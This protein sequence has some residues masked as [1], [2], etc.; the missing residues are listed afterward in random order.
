MH[1]RLI[2]IVFGVF[3]LFAGDCLAQEPKWTSEQSQQLLA[4]TKRLA[5]DEMQGRKPGTAGHEKAQEYLIDRF[6]TLELKTF[7]SGYRHGFEYNKALS[8]GSGV[9]L[10]GWLEGSDI[11]SSFIVYTAHYDHLG[12]SGNKIYNG[13]D[14]N[15]SGVSAMLALAEYFSKNMPK[16][17]MIF[18]ATDGEEA[19]LF[20]AKAFVGKPS[21]PLDSIKLNI[22]LDM[23]GQG[24][25]RNTLFVA[26]TKR[27]PMLK[28]IVKTLSEQTRSRQF[29]MKPGHD[30]RTAGFRNRGNER[31]NWHDASD[32]GP[33]I[34]KGIPY[35]YFGVDAHKH[36]HE[37]TDDFEHLDTEFFLQAVSAIHQTVIAVDNLPLGN[38]SR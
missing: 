12:K 15:A 38:L 36:Y 5:A 2:G 21:V 20:G 18:I 28:E 19:G 26:G 4:D 22:N 29:R 9:N 14:D 23:I 30:K 3:G 32:H 13:A 33:F 24:G 34:K 8:Y 7:G 35:L 37:V 16:H 1:K 27:Q 10:I 11:P 17:S 6:R 25:R 31:F